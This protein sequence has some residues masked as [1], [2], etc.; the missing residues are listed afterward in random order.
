MERDRAMQVLWEYSATH[1]RELSDE[2]LEALEQGC[3]A[4]NALM[5]VDRFYCDYKADKILPIEEINYLRQNRR[6]KYDD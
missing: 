5:L 1:T 4:L 6:R 3:Y 2:V